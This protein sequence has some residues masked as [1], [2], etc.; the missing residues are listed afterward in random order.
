MTLRLMVLSLTTI[1]YT[2]KVTAMSKVYEIDTSSLEWIN[3]GG[4]CMVAIA[5]CY[6]AESGTRPKDRDEYWIAAG[7]DSF[8]VYST[9]PFDEEW[10]DDIVEA[11][12]LYDCAIHGDHGTGYDFGEWDKLGNLMVDLYHFYDNCKGVM[13]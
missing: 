11:Y 2:R 3:T 10:R 4:N 9:Y 8:V 7:C 5:K 13:C 12:L 1:R 6:V